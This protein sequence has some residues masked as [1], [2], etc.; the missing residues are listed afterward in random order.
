MDALL[1]QA[2]N[3]D[4]EVVFEAG[5]RHRL[6]EHIKKAYTSIHI[7]S[8]EQVAGLY[9]S[10]IVKSLEA[11]HQVHTSIVPAGEA[12]KSMEQ[13]QY[14]L[15]RCVESKMDRNSLIIALGGGMIG[16]LAGFVASTYLRGVEFW[17][18]PTTIL[19]HDSSVG[20]KVAI[21]HP[22]GK[23]LIGS[24]YNPAKVVYDIETLATLPDHELRSGYGEVVK[25]AMLSD[26]EW[27]FDLLNSRIDTL[28]KDHIS[29]DLRKGIRVKADIVEQDEREHGIRKH[30]N[31]GHTLAHALEA[32]LGYGTVTHGEAVAVGILF[33]MQLSK[34]ILHSDLPVDDYVNWL[35]KNHY[36]MKVLKE[37]SPEVLVKR[38]KW[39]KKAVD[40]KIHYI[41]LE[42]IGTPILHQIS[43]KELHRHLNRFYSEVVYS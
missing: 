36:P 19:A 15:D 21:N 20:G 31:L 33:A 11:D 42:Q 6:S 13:Y 39:D 2:S 17:Q 23:N 29:N 18:M 9:L 8:D 27:L 35:G 30:L 5:V 26:K 4:Y 14:L 24:F 40:G 34:D 10:S 37:V 43:D 28:T 1:I 38:M 7:I 12:S 3:H 32:E 25:H 41:L 22:A 16:D